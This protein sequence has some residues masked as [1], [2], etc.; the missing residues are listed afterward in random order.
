MTNTLIRSKAAPLRAV[1]KYNSQHVANQY[2]LELIREKDQA[3]IENEE[4]IS[5]CIYDPT[6]PDVEESQIEALNEATGNI[7]PYFR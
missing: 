4:M 7:L 2:T 5:V 6:D 1:G 3:D